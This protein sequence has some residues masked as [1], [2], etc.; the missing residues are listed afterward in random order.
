MC[1]FLESGIHILLKLSYSQLY[2]GGYCRNKIENVVRIYFNNLFME[3]GLNNFLQ[4]IL[5]YCYNFHST[6]SN[7]FLYIL[8]QR[9]E[10]VTGINFEKYVARK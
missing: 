4:Y 2:I 6:F 3:R 8:S 5:L 10:N 9:V 1:H 7:N